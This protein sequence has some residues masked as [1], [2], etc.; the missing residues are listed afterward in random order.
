MSDN[1]KKLSEL[2]F[3]SNLS[4][5]TLAL[6][7]E[8]ATVHSYSNNEIIQQE[9]EP[10]LWAAFVISGS[11]QI[12]H[13]AKEGREQILA[14]LMPG[15]H[16]NTVPAVDSNSKNRASARS[17]G[18]TKLLKIPIEK[19]RVLLKTKA[20]LA[21]H[22]LTDFAHRLDHLIV[23]VER[24][25]LHSIRGRLANFLSDQ[26]DSRDQPNLWTQDDIASH[27]GTVRDV[28]GRTLRSSMDTGIFHR[29]SSKFILL[30]RTALEEET[31]F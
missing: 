20:D 1:Q 14:N 12:Y 29:E 22:V 3:F 4:H 17:L 8:C 10:C 9:G 7:E 21:Y 2:P 5:V 19:Y 18:K 24:L 25:S 31:Q 13:L 16:F 30:D 15:G 28:V 27:L 11:V 26:A 6:I 23:L